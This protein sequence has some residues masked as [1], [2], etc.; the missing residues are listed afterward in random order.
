MKLKK[1]NHVPCDFTCKLDQSL[2]LINKYSNHALTMQAL[3]YIQ[4]KN[5]NSYVV[6]RLK[7]VA[8]HPDPIQMPQIPWLPVP[9]KVA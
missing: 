4:F 1:F 8:K 2:D 7:L 3:E 6:N 9:E 5:R